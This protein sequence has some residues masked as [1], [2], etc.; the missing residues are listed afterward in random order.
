MPVTKREIEQAYME[1][2]DKYGGIKE[3]Y[4]ALLY[5]SKEFKCKPD[6]IAHQVAFGGND[7]G[8]DA[9]HVDRERKNLYLYQF[10]WS[11]NHNLFKESLLRLCKDGM[12]RIFG[13]PYQDQMQNQLLLQLKSTLVE[14]QSIIERVIIHFVFDGD[15]EDAEKSEKLDSLRE[16][17]ESK[18]F[19]IDQHFG[20]IRNVPLVFQFISNKSK[21]RSSSSHIRDTHKYSVEFA[22]PITRTT[23]TGEQ[24]LIGLIK[25]VDLQKMYK[26]MGMRLFEK[27]I[28]AG[29]SSENPPNRSIRQSL[30]RIVLQN[31]D[32]HDY[33]VFNHNG[34]TISAENVEFND[35][36][37]IF[38]EPRILNGAQTITSID[39]F[40]IDNENNHVLKENNDI[41]QSIEVMA[42]V[43][44]AK[45][46]NFIINVT[47]CNNRQN[48]VEP[49]NLRAS[50]HIQLDFADKF[51]NDLGIYYERQEKAF[52]ALTDDDLDEMGI[53]QYRAIEIKRL[54]QTLLATQGE[55]D[56]LSRLREVFENESIYFNTFKNRYISSDA[57]KILLAYKIQFRINRIIRQINDMGPNRYFYVGRCRNLIWSLMIQSILNDSNVERI[58]DQF[59]VNLGIEGEFN[60]LLKDNASR[61]IRPILSDVINDD[62]RYMQMIEDEKYS[63][64]RSKTL[65]QRCMAV[66]EDKWGWRKKDI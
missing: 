3:D 58:C 19:L 1:Y 42:K 40:L 6:D 14:N 63:F 64:L 13:N 32:P 26:D 10:K 12:E 48:P 43:V 2:K 56:K 30:S 60:E 65:Y 51:R 23:S 44:L 47:I 22:S 46:S 61:R 33:F 18:K 25:L 7:Y 57:R 37:C 11:E 24:L 54:A 45:N 21:A 38:T 34:V 20:N 16:D 50:D 36:H 27:N 15:P 41:L 53:D 49:W 52:D 59:G 4:F 39:K 17:L 35:G 55:L 28:R 9:F 29:L 5:L 8:I 62:E 31:T 66:A